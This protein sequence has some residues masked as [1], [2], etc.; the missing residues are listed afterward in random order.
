M[1]NEKYKSIGRSLLVGCAIFILLVC[2]LL[3]IFGFVTYYRG[4]IDKYQG[5]I[6]DVLQLAMTEIDADDM[7]NCVSTK[8]KSE[9]FEETQAFLDRI[10]ENFDIEF[11]YIIEPLNTNETDNVRNVMVGITAEERVIDYD[12]YSV[13]LGSLTGEDYSAKVAG[14]YLE[15]MNKDG[16]SYF[17]N[18]TEY[19]YDYT[20]ITPIKNKAGKAIAV[21]GVDVS[22]AEIQSVFM[23]YLLMLGAVI[24]V[25]AAA[26]VGIMYNW[27]QNRVIDPL[28]RLEETSV[29]F[30]ESSRTAEHPNDL[31]IIDQNI[32]TGD[33]MESLSDSMMKMFAD[34]KR[35]MSDL[36]T[37][38]KEKERIG[39][40]L[41]VATNIQADMLPRIFPAF[42]EREEFEI[43][44]SMNPAKEVGGD[45][46]DFF[47][48]D[49]NHIGL[50]MAD[51]SGK[52]IPAALF[53]V[54]SKTLIKNRAMMGGGPA[55]ILGFVNEQ[56]CEGNAAEMFVTVWFAIIDVQTGKGMAANAGHEHPVLRHKDGAY[57][58]I[59]YRH[60]LAVA[61][62][63]G[64]VFKE[65][66]FQLEP[67]DTIFVY[68][69]GVPEATNAN[70][71]LYG[72]E[73]MLKALNNNLDLNVNQL[74]PAVR[75]DVDE[76]VGEAPQFD[77][78]T[79]MGFYYKGPKSK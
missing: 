53:M 57:E 56:L 71:E 61:A 37:V 48:L 28:K 63:D 40:E 64:A 77:D 59:E 1:M 6:R 35:Y 65:H 49:D 8:T 74:L 39:A 42:P 58:L 13:E 32:K 38:T 25:L 5:Y 24:L 11:I 60:S 18:K 55:E 45:F 20:G 21:L 62:F 66:E 27:L 72:T 2:I 10:K 14:Q 52:G 26:A 43:Y 47:M 76:F 16:I 19:G 17:T 36:V 22:M 9:K 78:L 73:R 68:T 75:K 23:R 79:M 54:I 50:V 29:S 41:N 7:Q 67:G 12:Y 46:Y 70:G 34:M 30:V 31:R 4:M 3:G 44:A 15:G 51:V 69:D 33:E